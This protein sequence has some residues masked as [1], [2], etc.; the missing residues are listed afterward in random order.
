MMT[1]TQ[2]NPPLPVTTPQGPALAHL[3]IDYGPEHDL[4]W[5]CFQDKTGECWAWPNPKIRAPK[6]ITMGRSY[7]EYKEALGKA[8]AVR[9]RPPRASAGGDGAV[10]T[11]NSALRGGW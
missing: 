9:R 8:P 4:I 7:D 5:V 3:V 6:N 2:L 1:T 10:W 11:T